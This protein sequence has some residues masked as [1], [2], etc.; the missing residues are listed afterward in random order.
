WL[1]GINAFLFVGQVLFAP[2]T[3]WLDLRAGVG[4][5][6]TDEQI[7]ERYPDQFPEWEPDAR[8]PEQV[9][10]Q[11]RRAF[12]KARD[13]ALAAWRSQ[14]QG[15]GVLQGQVWRLVTYAFAHSRGDF[16]HIIFNMLFLWWFGHE[17]EEMYGSREFTLFYLVSAFVG[18]LGY[19][20]WALARDTNVPCVGASGAVTAVMVLY[21]FHYPTRVI[22][23]WWFLPI[24]IWL[25][26]AFQVAQDLFMFAGH[27]MET[28][29]AVSVH[30]AGAAFG[31]GYYKGNWRLA[32][33]WEAVSRLRLPRRRPRVRVYEEEEEAPV[34]R[35]AQP[36]APAPTGIT[37][38]PSP[39]ADEHLE[40][41]V[42]AVLE[43]VAR[44]GRDSLTEHEKALLVR[45]SEV[46][47][48]RQ[49]L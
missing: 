15:A 46:Y 6:L 4:P 38:K 11:Q 3:D 2:V 27:D 47:K 9:Q 23:L 25:F 33:L 49:R 31:F 5:H 10:Q 36:A 43:K 13:K 40:A 39:Q 28:T 37:T 19:F 48:R 22:R 32:P 29:T 42:D 1:I 24:P 8:W 41:Q 17:M 16:F 12:E 30:L 14:H 20:L 7:L 35:G 18:G 44:S 26:V 45:A 34:S 21:A